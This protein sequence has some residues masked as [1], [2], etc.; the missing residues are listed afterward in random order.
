MKKILI[1]T[2][3]I[4][5]LYSFRA[6]LTRELL[7]NGFEVLISAPYDVKAQYFVDEGCAFYD[8]KINRRSINPLS[9]LILFVKYLK[10]IKRLKPNIVLTYT[11][12]PNV[13][14]GIACRLM[15]KPFLSN[16]TGLGTAVEKD[17]LLRN[18][19]LSM[20]GVGLKR[21]T[22]VFFQN[23][24]NANLFLEKHIVEKDKIIL[25]P[26]SGVNIKQHY[27]EE[28]PF[29]QDHIKFM[30]IGRLM[31]AKGC[32]ELFEASKR[33]KKLYPKTEFHIIGVFEEDLEKQID[34]LVREKCIIYHGIQDDVH[35]FLKI[36][37]AVINPSHH[38][39]MSN[40]LLEAASTGRPILASKIPG[41]METF[42][43]GVS[44]FGFE[45]KNIDSIT[46]TIIRFIKLSHEEKR[47]MGIQGRKKIELEFN[48]KLVIK[49][50]I[51]EINTLVEGEYQ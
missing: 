30:F 43:E 20:Y 28:Y 13:Y 19:S 7:D 15:Q 4:R 33:I 49:K 32:L 21:A 23:Q 41:C 14:G 50:Y 12:K 44:G 34:E 38:E 51:E 9:D 45:V 47:I 31:E 10:L 36:S 24:S 8:T 29:E 2:N 39:G 11:I 18:I 27:F 42:Q 1:L 46:D 35:R 5:G 22:K 26:G 37:N 25:I 40:V 6:E 3:S 16:I 48:R 17:G